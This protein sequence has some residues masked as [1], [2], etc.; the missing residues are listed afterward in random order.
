MTYSVESKNQLA[1]LLATENLTIEHRKVPTASFDMKNRVLTCP[2]W[3]DMSGDLYD[4][5][6]GHEVGHALETPLDGW[7]D[8]VSNKGKNYKH[9]LNVVEDARIEKKIKRR[10]PGLKRSFVSAY[11]RLFDENFFGVKHRNL[12]KLSL[13]DKINLYFK[14]G[15]STGIKF[16]DTEMEFV[17]QIESCE[18]WDDVVVI[19]DKLFAYCKEEQQQINQNHDFGSSESYEIDEEMDSGISLP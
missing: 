2:I 5:F 3:K 12:N 14:C 1:K 18:T 6:L 7:H 9:F 19:T 4:L 17:N 15:I 16:N 13:V 8:S 10:Y 11:N